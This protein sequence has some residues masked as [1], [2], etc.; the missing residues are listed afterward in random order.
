M[1][2]LASVGIFACMTV[3]VLNVL[4]R[5]FFN[6]PIHGTYELVQYT[7]LLTVA[8]ALAENELTGGNVRVSFLLEKMSPRTENI[9]NLITTF[10]VLIASCFVAYTQFGIV[11]TKYKNHA[12]TGELGIPHW[13]LVL[14]LA[15]GFLTLTFTFALEIVTMIRQHK[16]LT[17]KKLTADEIALKATESGNLM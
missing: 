17:D 9:V 6:A 7:L 8:L 14:I 3:V 11:S 1:S 10:I 2:T 13:I 15:V 16:T 12:I 5:F 4:T